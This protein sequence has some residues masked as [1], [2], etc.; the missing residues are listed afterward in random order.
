MRKS[1]DA[2]S[3]LVHQG[4]GRDPL[5]GDMGGV[6]KGLVR[7]L[8]DPR[9]PIDNNA[10]GRALRGVVARGRRARR[11]PAD[12]RPRAVRGERIPLPH[13]LAVAAPAAV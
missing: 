13:E 2:L 9:V 4:L 1:F 6:W 10:T 5:C 12:R 11:V 8:D 3:A 7:F